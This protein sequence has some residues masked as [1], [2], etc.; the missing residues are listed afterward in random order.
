MFCFLNKKKKGKFPTKPPPNQNSRVTPFSLIFS[1]PRVLSPVAVHP[2]YVD[3]EQQGL[4][5]RH[6]QHLQHGALR[7]R[8]CSAAAQRVEPSAP[9]GAFQGIL[10][11]SGFALC[12]VSRRSCANAPACLHFIVSRLPPH[13]PGARA[14]PQR[15]RCAAQGL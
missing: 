4:L 7:Y 12:C 13:L 8:P 2:M 10:V 14:L 3:N 11:P 9:V 6:E 1:P 15:Q 5:G